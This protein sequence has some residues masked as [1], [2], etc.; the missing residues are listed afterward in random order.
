MSKLFR[1]RDRESVK[2]F[3]YEYLVF[4]KIQTFFRKFAPQLIQLQ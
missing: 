3:Y 2:A 4:A 1:I